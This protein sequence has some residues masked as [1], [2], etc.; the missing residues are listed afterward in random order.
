MK[1]KKNKTKKRELNED[2]GSNFIFGNN[3]REIIVLLIIVFLIILI[4]AYLMYLV[5]EN[6]FYS[7]AALL[8][9]TT[10]AYRFVKKST[11][12]DG[13]IIV[14]TVLVFALPFLG[15]HLEENK[16]IEKLEDKLEGIEKK[17]DRILSPPEIKIQESLPGFSIHMYASF[18]SSNAKQRKFIYDLGSLK[19]ERLSLYID[20][21]DNFTF[22]L[23]DSLDEPHLLKVPI[24]SKQFPLNKYIYLSCEVAISENSTQLQIMVNGQV[25]RTE[26]LPF[27]IDWGKWNFIGSVLGAS[28][29]KEFGASFDLSEFITYEKTLTSESKL[30]MYEYFKRKNRTQ[31]I[32]F[33]EN[34]WMWI[35]GPKKNL[36]QDNPKF[37]PTLKVIE[38]N[39]KR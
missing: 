14:C 15:Q 6:I 22:Q 8:L 39:K 35:P 7:I 25:V 29:N 2:Y 21:F 18:R 5:T 34:Q 30:R 20:P 19:K 38:K 37:Q 17:I 33:E 26:N 1:R 28:L 9:F 13:V 24:G 16:D 4:I 11:I 31:V 32:S 12:K 3:Q 27:K 23:I 36:Q 10:S